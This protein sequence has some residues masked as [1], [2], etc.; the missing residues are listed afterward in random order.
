MQIFFK[1]LIKHSKKVNIVPETIEKYKSVSTE[2]FI[3]IDSFNFLSSSIEKLVEDLKKEGSE[4]FTR[5]KKHFPVDKQFQLLLR[6]GVYFYDY[7]SDFKVFSET[8]LPSP[9]NFFNK[10]HDTEIS[11]K[12][13]QHA[14]NVFKAF[15]CQTLLE[16]MELYVK[17][18]TLLLADIFEN[19]RDIAMKTYGLDPVHYIS[20]P[21]FGRDAM[22][23]QTGVEIEL[24]SDPEI[25]NLVKRGV[26]GGTF[27]AKK[28]ISNFQE[29]Y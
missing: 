18:D 26:R 9:K 21:S 8:K 29:T 6:K 12:D 22:L 11:K 19:F 13:Y 15:N 3:F 2:E 23:K 20:L 25:F 5:L 4:C 17:T 10:L 7:A 14:E 24:I 1:E 16:Y 28:E 27:K